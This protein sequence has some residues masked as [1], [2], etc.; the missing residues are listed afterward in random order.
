MQTKYVMLI[1][2]WFIL[3]YSITLFPQRL[4]S[5]SSGFSSFLKLKKQ[6]N[7][8]RLTCF[9]VQAYAVLNKV[10]Q[11]FPTFPLQCTPSAFRQISM[12]PYGMYP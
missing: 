9:L 7:V 3:I 1:Y 10:D 6:S 12:Y 11:G 2:L 8:L 4:S 5:Y